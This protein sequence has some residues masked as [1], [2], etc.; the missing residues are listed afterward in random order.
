M[1]WHGDHYYGVV[2]IIIGMDFPGLLGK[3]DRAVERCMTH[4]NIA[5]GFRLFPTIVIFSNFRILRE[6]SPLT[7]I[8][9][10]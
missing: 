9:A 1:H 4:G 7:A 5:V 3:E 8:A 10:C 6:T 2:T